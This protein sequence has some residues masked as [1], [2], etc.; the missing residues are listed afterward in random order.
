[1]TLKIWGWSVYR[2]EE[3]EGRRQQCVFHFNL[4]VRRPICRTRNYLLGNLLVPA[5]VTAPPAPATLTPTHLYCLLISCQFF[6]NIFI[7]FSEAGLSKH[8]SITSRPLP[9]A[10]LVSR[11][12]WHL[13]SP[14]TTIWIFIFSLRGTLECNFWEWYNR[15]PRPAT[16]TDDTWMEQLREATVLQRPPPTESCTVRQHCSKHVTLRL[17][18]LFPVV[19]QICLTLLQM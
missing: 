7:N 13:F 12:H 17:S 18:F 4:V 6:E 16:V 11:R 8:F 10:S 1:M 3:R 14:F 15:F 2:W 5:A 19:L 9:P